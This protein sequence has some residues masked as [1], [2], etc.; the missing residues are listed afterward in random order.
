MSDESKKRELKR[1]W[2]A[3]ERQ[4]LLSS[5][6]LGLRDLRDLFD[7]LDRGGIE[8]D[9]TLRETIEFLQLRG[10]EVVPVVE[11]LLSR[12]MS[13]RTKCLS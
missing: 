12:F 13:S 7:H 5:I 11:W 2:K 8:C 9:H 3:D 10:I 4:K 1:T 6:P